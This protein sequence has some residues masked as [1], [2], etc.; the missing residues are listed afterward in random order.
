LVSPRRS[1]P[2]K[3]GTHR[4][5]GILLICGPRVEAHKASQQQLIDVTST[6]LYLLDVPI[7]LAMDSRPILEAF[8][9]QAVTQR[10]PRYSDSAADRRLS[11]DSELSKE[12]ISDEDAEEVLKRLRGLGYIE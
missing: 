6:I 10:A 4:D 2:H 3:Q 9:R 7:P 1:E 11:Y 8:Q 5:E 12:G